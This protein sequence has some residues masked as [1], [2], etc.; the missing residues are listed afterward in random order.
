MF[1]EYWC[2]R[3]S[4]ALAGVRVAE[5]VMPTERNSLEVP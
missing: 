5:V 3:E 4:T 2:G 1:A